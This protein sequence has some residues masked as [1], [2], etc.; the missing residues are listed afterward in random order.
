MI[1]VTN[2]SRKT[3]LGSMIQM[4]G[5]FW[6]RWIGLTSKKVI[7]E[8]EGM[9]FPRCKS[10]HT[11]GMQFA[12]DVV[13][14]DEKNRILKTFSNLRPNRFVLPRLKARA[15]LE[16]PAGTLQRS[17]TKPGDQLLFDNGAVP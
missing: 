2:Q 13:I 4:A 9:F 3:S 14:L 15:I 8:G 5:S 17:T 6:Q 7:L 10:I 16:L 1:T 11:L 12:I